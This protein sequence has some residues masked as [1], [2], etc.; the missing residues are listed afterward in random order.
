MELRQRVKN[1]SWI[2]EKDSEELTEGGTSTCGK[3]AS[4]ALG[5]TL[6]S[7]PSL[8]GLWISWHAADIMDFHLPLIFIFDDAEGRK[9][10]N[11][12]HSPYPSRPLRVQT[13]T[14]RSLLPLPL[15]RGLPPILGNHSPLVRRLLR[16]A[17]SNS[18][19]TSLPSPRNL[20]LE[21]ILGRR[22]FRRFLRP[23][24]GE[25]E[26]PYGSGRSWWECSGRKECA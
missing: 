15:G 4:T 8:R 26:E 3:V 25:D 16:L 6:A 13:S 21:S 19:R 9:M 2:F 5:K 17:S 7:F 22:L 12:K 23:I 24:V 18:S 10:D 20:V 11:L 14:V 1:I